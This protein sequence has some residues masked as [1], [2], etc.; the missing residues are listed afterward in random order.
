MPD[1]PW[2]RDYRN[3]ADKILR[4][5]RL[6]FLS[7]V[8]L[9][10]GILA[11]WRRRIF[12]L[13]ELPGGTEPSFVIYSIIP[14]SGVWQRP[15]HFAVRLAQKYKVLYVDPTGIQHVV[16]ASGRPA[17]ELETIS[18]HL[19]V[20]RPRVLPGG[21]TKPWITDVN[22][23]LV[24][25]K[26]R[27]LIDSADF[28][29]PV[30]I[31]NTPLSDTIASRLNWSA[32][33]YDVIDD[34]V[35]ASWAPPDAVAREQ[36][37]FQSAD[38]VFTGTYSLWEKKRSFHDS[39][40]FIPCGV[41]IEHFSKAD[42]PELPVP[43]DIRDL[44]P[45]VFGYFG[46]LNERLDAD[47]LVHLAESFPNGS[48]VLI[49]PIFADF[50][51][52]D[53]TDS[54]SSVLQTPDAPGFRTKP[55]PSNLHILGIRPYSGLPEYL[56]AFDICLL[57]YILNQVTRDIHPVKILEYLASG[58]PVISTPLP[59]VKRFYEDVVQIADTPEAFT[60]AAQ[61]A[62][63]HEDSQSRSLRVNFARPKT[64]EN[65]TRA[66]MNAMGRHLNKT[67]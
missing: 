31:T 47:L 6:A 30:F 44:P 12:G 50:G 46:A 53:F 55:I 26:L 7:A 43:D 25:D 16:A 52:S 1:G 38:T 3:M 33:I 59:D 34:F 13:P 37:L 56:K 27:L 65:M 41:E 66:M 54:W 60:R 35:A 11:D 10:R 23:A 15:Q 18:D 63:E 2:R 36:R 8:T 58:R 5:A 42:D 21:K 9:L 20:F 49:G 39:I 67:L 24:L 29:S 48:V 40:E 14:W 57:P 61:D 32:I 22:D 4:I 19:T 17:P 51:L 64:W 45:P 62:L 28:S